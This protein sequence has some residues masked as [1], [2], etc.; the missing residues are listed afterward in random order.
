MGEG[1]G[2]RSGLTKRLF[3]FFFSFDKDSENQPNPVSANG[4]GLFL[5]I[6]Y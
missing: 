3:S 1:T 5:H 4:W 6:V 2:P